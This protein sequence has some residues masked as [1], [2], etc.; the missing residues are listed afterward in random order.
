MAHP[1]PPRE[2]QVSHLVAHVHRRLDLR[3]VLLRFISSVR[4]T[5]SGK[6]LEPPHLRPVGMLLPPCF[7][8]RFQRNGDGTAP[9]WPNRSASFPGC[10]SACSPFIVR[11]GTRAKLVFSK[12]KTTTAKDTHPEAICAVHFAVHPVRR[13]REYR[14]PCRAGFT[15][16]AAG[17]RLPRRVPRPNR[18]LPPTPLGHLAAGDTPQVA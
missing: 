13:R 2:Q 7:G 9:E 11:V 10:G 8:V 18:L 4:A 12:K 6:F 5:D 14:R 15:A 3:H 16:R 1:V 17:C